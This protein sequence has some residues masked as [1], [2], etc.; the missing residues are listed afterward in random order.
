MD[1]L[2]AGPGRAKERQFWGPL[3]G[4]AGDSIKRI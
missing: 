2:T 3:L 1:G 4:F